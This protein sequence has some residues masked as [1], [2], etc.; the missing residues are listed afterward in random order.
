MTVG[1]A[2]RTRAG[3][4]EIR[5]RL[6]T[7]GLDLFHTNGYHA[8]GVQD[9]ANAAGVPKG[10]FYNHFD[11]KQ[12]LAII[13]V[14]RYAESGPLEMLM[15]THGR[16]V[17]AIRSHFEELALRFERA[18]WRQGCM[19]GNFANEL[20]DQDEDVR[21][22]VNTLLT[23][24]TQLLAAAIAQ[25]QG[26]GKIAATHDAD[27]LAGTVLSMWEGSLT[28]ARAARSKAPLDEFFTITFD[29]L[30]ASTGRTPRLT[31]DHER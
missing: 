16:P 19:I 23:G 6:I 27:Q 30:L 26:L 12:A 22:A 21:A 14:Q 7:A 13:A 18:G 5:E 15:E 9:I 28:R 3:S 17:D 20:A 29:S 1:T 24:W 2:K 31:K 4:A 10:S 25:A 11:S 8:T